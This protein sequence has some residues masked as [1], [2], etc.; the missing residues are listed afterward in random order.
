MNF[1]SL[2]VWFLNGMIIAPKGAKIG[3]WGWTESYF[4]MYK[5]QI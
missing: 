5:T 2:Y 4:F 3:S 1:F